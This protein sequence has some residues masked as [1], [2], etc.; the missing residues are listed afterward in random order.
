MQE[1]EIIGIACPGTISNGVILKA[2]NLGLKEYNLKKE[3][4]AIWNKTVII[5]NDGKC[6]GLAEKTVGE[7]KPY[8]D[9]IFINIG[10]RNRRGSILKWK[11]IKPKDMFRI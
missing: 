11:T 4:E 8:D 7:I 6:A 3:I 5:K 10:T 2:G 9:A 1:I